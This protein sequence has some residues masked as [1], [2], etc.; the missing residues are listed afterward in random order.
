[1][2]LTGKGF[3]LEVVITDQMVQEALSNKVSFVCATCRKFWKGAE[4][5]EQCEA[6]KEGKPCGGPIVGLDFPEYDGMM[7]RSSLAGHCF[8]CGNESDGV[9]ERSGGKLVGFCK[10]HGPEWIDTLTVKKEEKKKW[11]ISM[12]SSMA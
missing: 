10:R 7:T 12:K 4:R 3:G 1:M 11:T 6:F 2:T 5:G 9:M 8:V